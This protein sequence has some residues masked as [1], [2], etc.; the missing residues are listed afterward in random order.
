MK[1]QN[2]F[3]LAAVVVALALLTS[4]C[5][6]SFLDQ[7]PQGGN[8]LQTQ[9]EQLSNTLSGS[10][11]GIYTLLYQFTDHDQFGQR[12]IDMYTDLC[13]GDM[14]LTA[15]NYGWFYLDEY[16]R[17]RERTAYFWAYYYDIIHN[18]NI[19]LNLA[20]A[21]SEVVRKIKE[22]GLP[23]DGLNVLAGTDTLCKYTEEEAVVAGYYAQ[24][25]TLRS[26]AYS[27]L[28][29]YYSPAPQDILSGTSETL[30]GRFKLSEV[31]VAPIYT[32]DDMDSPNPRSTV[33]DFFTRVEQ[34]LTLAVSI[35]DAF[36]K[37]LVR[38]NKLEVD[39][40]VARGLL[41]YSYLNWG[42][43]NDIASQQYYQKAFDTAKQLIDK[44]AYSIIP[45]KDLLTTGFNSVNSTSWIWGEEVT[46]ETATGL[47][48][49]FGQ[50]DIHSYSYAWSGDTKV[51]D[52]ELYDSIPAWDGRRKWFNDGKANP[53]Y[54]LCP[55]GKFFSAVNPTSTSEDDIDRAWE[56]DNV[57]M[58]IELM[59]LIAAEAAYRLGN[60]DDCRTYLTAITDQRLDLTAEDQATVS[61]QY[62]AW[63]TALADNN[64][65]IKALEL[66]WRVELWGEGY[67]FQTLKRLTKTIKK[68]K[69]HLYASGQELKS[70]QAQFTFSIPSSETLYNPHIDP[71][72]MTKADE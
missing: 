34:D 4:S 62:A 11:F 69:N 48:S 66:N 3:N 55:D 53:T 27:N 43:P 10:L 45:N 18:C 17:T 38:N 7:Y 9:Y 54:K 22:F 52:E 63:K 51:I 13:C 60:Y 20:N 71:K 59:Y 56:S 37:Y 5:S 33:Y 21:Q 57:Y 6:D 15:R 44:N 14:A 39:G 28:V 23:N 12:S 36:D 65:L 30:G 1:K 40:S 32:E 46:V 8:I 25:I 41:A 72:V 24:A 2:R 29:R 49:F 68:G 26:Y 50:V 58:R 64:K 67:G 35:F 31:Y 61:S 70:T 47:G 16:G 19:V 42:N